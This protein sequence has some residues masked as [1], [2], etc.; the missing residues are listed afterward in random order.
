MLCLA[1]ICFMYRQ[2]IA[3]WS[4][5]T[6]GFTWNEH[7]TQ[8]FLDI[9]SSQNPGIVFD[10]E[11][12]QKQA[13]EK[14]LLYFVKNKKWPWSKETTRIYMDALNRNPFVRTNPQLAVYTVQS[15][16]NESA[17]LQLLSWQA[18][19]GQFLL[20]GVTVHSKNDPRGKIEANQKK[21][22]SRYKK[23]N[24]AR[25]TQQR[26]E[27][28][29]EDYELLPSGWGEFAYN[30]DQM[31]RSDND[32]LY[33]CA[34]D[35]EGNLSMT[36]IRYRGYN[37][38]TGVRLKVSKTVPN[39]ELETTIPG[40]HFIRKNDK[41]KFTPCNPCEALNETPSYTCPFTIKTSGTFGGT[42]PVWK[43]LWGL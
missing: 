3:K 5:I 22:N 25:E 26:A 36:K 10:I 24:E 32:P 38:I 37:N 15:I 8:Q 13:S 41:K 2:Q 42:S 33:K 34:Y 11:E 1:L 27:N 43:Y 7:L 18:K 35:R 31:H 9:Q 20:K 40:F 29:N 16:Y 4:T 6:E 28:E 39:S 14:E 23:V 30:S 21:V 19:E 17:I 12:I